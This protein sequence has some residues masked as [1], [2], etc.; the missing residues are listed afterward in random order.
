MTGHDIAL[1]H[2]TTVGDPLEPAVLEWAEEHLGVTVHD[3]YG[4][5]EC[6]GVVISNLPA[7]PINPGS[8]GRPLPGA[9]VAVVDPEIGVELE[10]GATGEIAWR[11]SP[12]YFEGY[13]GEE[14][15][16][17][18]SMV[19]GWY[20]AGDLAHRDADGSVWFEGRADDVIL[21]AGHRIGPFEVERAMA[22][23]PAV[24]DA[25][26]V[27]KPDEHRGNIVT[28]FVAPTA[29]AEPTE[30]LTDDIAE[31]VRE[32]PSAHEYPREVAFR[33]ELPRT[34]AGKIRRTELR[35][36]VG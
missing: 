16:P 19:G 5:T 1:R 35:D 3:T 9:A 23:H 10:P 34:V 30:A 14:H 25:A 13:R 27:P 32:S 17:A 15:R 12:A 21:S 20:L 28:A 8:M 6:G 4:Q 26:V 18:E 29:G 11:D 24:A 36:E 7:L 22:E 33:G 31:G 2:A